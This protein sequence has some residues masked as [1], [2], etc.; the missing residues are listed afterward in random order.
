MFKDTDTVSDCNG[1]ST[2]D[3]RTDTANHQDNMSVWFISHYI[4]L[5]YSKTGV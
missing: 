2:D 4:P 3:E 5:L 1:G